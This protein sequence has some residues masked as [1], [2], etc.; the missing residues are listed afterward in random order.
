[1]GIER[2]LFAREHTEPN[3][4]EEKIDASKRKT[5]F[6]LGALAAATAL[7]PLTAEASDAPTK[8]GVIEVD[9]QLPELETLTTPEAKE[10][11]MEKLFR[12][13]AWIQINRELLASLHYKKDIEAVIF[14]DLP[15]LEESALEDTELDFKEAIKQKGW[16]AIPFRNTVKKE[17]ANTFTVNDVVFSNG[18]A[19]EG[20]D[21]CVLAQDGSDLAC[22]DM[23]NAQ[24]VSSHEIK[25][26]RREHALTWNPENAQEDLHGRIVFIPT[27]HKTKSGYVE[28]LVPAVLVK[29]TPNFLYEGKK[30]TFFGEKNTAAFKSEFEQSYM[31]VVAPLDS[32][33][34]G[35]RNGSDVTGMSGSPLLTLEDCSLGKRDVSGIVWG[36]Q[37]RKDDATKTS[38]S[39]V[40]VHGADVIERMLTQL[41]RNYLSSE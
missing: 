3:E 38:R 26:K 31:A 41:D 11:N 33:E 27:T 15:A 40:F 14:K 5:L 19:F 25:E 6:G 4:P 13:A 23:D 9:P 12:Y 30:G 24:V 35:V 2:Y 32:D 10:R 36:T 39:I 8:V 18:H 17:V 16:P 34:N 1:M 20:L 22:A 28:E 7:S 37:T 21:G 29:I